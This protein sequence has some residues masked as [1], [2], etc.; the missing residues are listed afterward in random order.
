MSERSFGAFWGDQESRL[1]K[2]R[3]G[4]GWKG[5]RKRLWAANQQ[6]RFFAQS[7]KAFRG[8]L[9]DLHH[10]KELFKQSR[11][12]SIKVFDFVDAQGW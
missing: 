4:M 10:S 3:Y 11:R 1:K 12:I 8:A 7:A 6:G 9:R 5:P 2:L